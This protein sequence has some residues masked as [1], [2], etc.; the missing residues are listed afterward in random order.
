MK[1][2]LRPNEYIRDTTD[3]HPLVFVIPNF[4]FIIGVALLLLIFNRPDIF[5]HSN[6]FKYF[7]MFNLP[8]ITIIIGGILM[9]PLLV[10]HLDNHMKT[11]MVT[12]QRV[13]FRRGIVAVTERN[14]P[15]T[16]INDVQLEQS[17]VQRLFNSGD[18]VIQTGNDEH[19]AIKDITHP[20]EF[21][22]QILFAIRQDVSVVDSKALM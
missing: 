12:N 1:V 6:F 13:C 11:Y 7:S 22:N 4:L 19:V 3:F 9:I 8:M 21:R 16:K 18:I 2:A 10:K 14:V 5:S 20:I 17:F 15:L